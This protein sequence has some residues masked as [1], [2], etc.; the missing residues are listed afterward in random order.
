MCIRDRSE[1]SRR[2]GGVTSVPQLLAQGLG[3]L[4]GRAQAVGAGEELGQEQNGQFGREPALET[5]QVS[6]PGTPHGDGEDVYKRQ[7]LDL[8]QRLVI[9]PCSVS[10]LLFTN[11]G[12]AILCVNSTGSLGELALS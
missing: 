4:V 6:G 9:S 11:G 2:R 5:L 3:H 12:P 10:A 1:R 7:P 8:M